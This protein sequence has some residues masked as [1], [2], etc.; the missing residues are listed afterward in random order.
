MPAYLLY[1][2]AVSVGVKELNKIY[3]NGKFQH[4]ER[5]VS[6]VQDLHT[7]NIA[8]SG[9]RALCP[10]SHIL[11]HIRIPDTAK[12]IGWIIRDGRAK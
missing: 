8:C 6:I 9:V 11:A 7:V 3:R 1:L 4:T 12:G 10:S 5:K 2:S